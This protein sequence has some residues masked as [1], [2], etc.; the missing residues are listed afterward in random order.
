MFNT[1][2]KQYINILQQNK[3]LKIEYK[4]VQDAKILKKEH[5]SFLMTDKKLSNDAQ[6]KLNA[7]Q[8]NISH[9]YIATITETENQEV[10]PTNDV[11]TISYNSVKIGNNHSIVIPKN[12]I[13]STLNYFEETGI[14]FII[15]P[16][17]IIEKH[18]EE[19]E[20]KNS[21]NF[22]IYN[23]TIYLIIYNNQK[24]ILFSKTKLLTP[25]ESMKDDTFLEDEIVGQK[26]YEEV[27]FLEIEQFLNES[28]QE[29]YE[30]SSDGVFLEN[31]SM[32]YTLRPM[33]DE[34]I[35]ILQNNLIIPINYKRISVDN[36]LSKITQS[37]HKDKYNFITKRDKKEESSLYLWLILIFL[38]IVL[39]AIIISFQESKPEPLKDQIETKPLNTEKVAVVEQKKEDVSLKPVVI[40]LP[41]HVQKNIH[42]VQNIKMLFGVLPYDAVLQEIEIQKDRS[43][44]VSN[45][46]V[47]SDSIYDLQT[48]LKNIYSSSKILLDHQ[49]KIIRN[50]IIQNDTVVHPHKN[51]PHK[52]YKKMSFF[53]TSEATT[54]LSKLA[55]KDSSI[56]FDG[57]EKTD[58]LTY[59][60]SLT[61]TVKEP[62]EFF[63]FI[64]KL[65]TQKASIELIYPIIFS[66]KTDSLE[67]KYQIRLHQQ[68]K[69][70]ISLKK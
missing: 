13:K 9:T 54:Y 40:S 5:S 34:Q 31:I 32:L 51:I 60:F 53:S 15:S 66:Q 24:E 64:N 59:N 43:T 45:F 17:T 1:N 21:L 62:I 6:F 4:I 12:E 36:Y 50:V 69:K 70:Q 47:N 33:S 55:I 58:H 56:T 49:N 25:F 44:Y 14:D 18:L 8:K 37:I 67:I 65:N 23:N 63:E 7:L 28:I 3:Q 26:L 57:K 29:Y 20:N 61:S 48:K 11:D 27:N 10:I 68:N 35:E 42:I 30:K 16:F 22:L 2:K 38:S 52:E 46:V 41:D 19:N 39:V